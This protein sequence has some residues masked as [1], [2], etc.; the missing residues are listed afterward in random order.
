MLIRLF[1]PLTLLTVACSAPAGDLRDPLG[2]KRSDSSAHLVAE[3]VRIEENTSVRISFQNQGDL[4]VRL[5]SLGSGAYR[6]WKIDPKSIPEPIDSPTGWDGRLAIEYEGTHMKIVWAPA[7]VG[8]YVAP[9]DKL[10][11][12]GFSLDVGATLP[13]NLPFQAMF[14]DGTCVWSH[15]AIAEDSSDE[16]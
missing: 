12:L 9:G 10:T 4:G 14:A 7:T 2:C 5:I 6:S 13:A 16:P 15:L 1:V 11:G 8:D 3:I